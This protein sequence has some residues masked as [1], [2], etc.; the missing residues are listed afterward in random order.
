M[1]VD[2][3]PAGEV[4][5]LEQNG[6]LAFVQEIQHEKVKVRRVKKTATIS[7]ARS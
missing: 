1:S 5:M 6:T 2:H 4:C 3:L 7:E